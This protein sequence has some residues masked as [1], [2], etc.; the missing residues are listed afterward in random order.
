MVVIH[1]N[2][3]NELDSS[4]NA[5]LK[6]ILLTGATLL[7]QSV[8]LR[9]I[10]D[11]EFTLIALSKKLFEMN[12]IPYYL[13]ALDR[14]TGTHHF[15]VTLDQSKLLADRLRASL[16]GYLVP[17]LVQEVAGRDSKTPIL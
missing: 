5:A 6:R 11:S 17:K 14:A 7:N 8:L 15:E 12:V 9:D 4:V 10:N 2:H 1:C 16:P 3:P 13:H